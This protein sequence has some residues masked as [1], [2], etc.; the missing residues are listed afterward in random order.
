MKEKYLNTLLLYYEEE[1]MGEGYFLS[2]SKH[3]TEKHQK[4]KMVMMAEVER[5]AAKSVMPLLQKYKLQPRPTKILQTIGEEGVKKI[6]NLSWIE[7]IQ[8][9][10]DNYPNYLIEFA[11]LEALAPSED[12]PLMQILTNHEFAAIEFAELELAGVNLSI[13]PLL[14]YMRK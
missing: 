13:K 6:V 11:A 7:F 8:Q 12:L 2:L 5:Y 4:E 9:I 3:I 10:N 1:I 14:E